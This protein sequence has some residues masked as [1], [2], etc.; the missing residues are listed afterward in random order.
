[1]ILRVLPFSSKDFFRSKVRLLWT[2]LWPIIQGLT[3]FLL[4]LDKAFVNILRLGSPVL[5]RLQGI[6]SRV[7]L[8]F[9]GGDWNTWDETLLVRDQNAHSWVEVWSD[10]QQKWLDM[11]LP[12]GCDQYAHRGDLANHERFGV[13]LGGTADAVGNAELSIRFAPSSGHPCVIFPGSSW[14]GSFP[15][16]SGSIPASHDPLEAKRSSWVERYYQKICRDLIDLQLKKGLSEG[17]V[18]FLIEPV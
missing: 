8:G 5:M 9:F 18:H 10:S 3:R 2:R 1:M 7:V 16:D 4:R 17:P 13:P 6:P 14:P 12:L 11:I 15:L